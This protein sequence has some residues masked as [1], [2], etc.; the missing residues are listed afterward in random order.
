MKHPIPL[1]V[2]AALALLVTACTTPPPVHGEFIGKDG[3]ILV[4][5][6]GRIV[7]TVEPRTAK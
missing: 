3:R 4:E 5:P 7:V 2:A 1:L 6:G